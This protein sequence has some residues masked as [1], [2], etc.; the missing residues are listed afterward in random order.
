MAKP[1]DFTLKLKDAMRMKKDKGKYLLSRFKSSKNT[2]SEVARE[3]TKSSRK[4]FL[5]HRCV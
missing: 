1:E 5:L 3:D 4:T 2:P